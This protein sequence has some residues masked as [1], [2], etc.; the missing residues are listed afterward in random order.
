MVE[1]A[2][3]WYS[4]LSQWSAQVGEPLQRLL[5]GQSIPAVSALLLG[6]I[7][8]LAPCQVTANAGAIAYVSQGEAPLWRTVR[9]YLAGKA[10]VYLILG[11]LAAMLGLKLP[12]PVMALMRKLNGPLLILMGLYF[13]GVLNFKSTAGERM[14][15]WVKA[16]A[17][18]RGSPALWLGIAFSLG[19]CPTMAMIFFGA[20]V[21]LVV[22]AQ[23]GIILPVFFAIGTALPVIIWAGALSA[24]KGVAGRWIK[25]VR[26]FD[27]VVRVLVAGTFLL[28]G[29]NDTVL[30]WFT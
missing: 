23:A 24:G 10:G 15:A 17:P 2:T 6:L 22:Q 8:G 18:R 20:L 3:Q 4:W 28:L 13:L 5:A 21:P 12:T 26:R 30:Y 25:G 7:G 19:F 29:L 11:F 14:T 1:L 27:V 9:D 16:H